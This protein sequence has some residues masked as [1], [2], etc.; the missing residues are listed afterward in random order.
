MAGI[1]GLLC[2]YRQEVALAAEDLGTKFIVRTC[3]KRMAKD[4]GTSVAEVMTESLAQGVNQIRRRTKEG[5]NYQAAL[6]IKF[7]NF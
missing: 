6:E 1:V 4:G 3:A 5:E 2:F 7:E